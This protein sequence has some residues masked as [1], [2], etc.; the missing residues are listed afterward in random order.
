MTQNSGP[1]GSSRRSVEPR[2]QLLPGP[3]VH[4]DL[5]AAAALA[6]AHEQRA[7]AGVEVG[8]GERERLVDPQPGAPEHDDQAA[9]PPAVARRRRRRA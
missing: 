5:A 3:L 9:Q 4:A 2:L 6:A 8:L 1:T 7:A